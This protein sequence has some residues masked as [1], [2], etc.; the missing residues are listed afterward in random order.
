[1]KNVSSSRGPYPRLSSLRALRGSRR[2]LSALAFSLV[3]VVLVLAL[4]RVAGA[5]AP[6]L[7]AVSDFEART[8]VLAARIEWKR[9]PARPAAPFLGSGALAPPG[10]ASASGHAV[11]APPSLPRSLVLEGGPPKVDPDL[12]IASRGCGVACDVQRHERRLR[13]FTDANR[14]WLAPTLGGLA[15]VSQ[16]MLH[17]AFYGK[18]NKEEAMPLDKEDVHA[19]SWLHAGTVWTLAYVAGADP[20][21]ALG[22]AIIASFFFQGLLNL[23]ISGTFFD[24]NESTCWDTY[25]GLC[26]PKVFTGRNNYA[27]LAI[28]TAIIVVPRIIRRLR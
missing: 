8:G 20:V 3:P 25:G 7:S 23:G 21:D 1:M 15:F 12:F 28:G 4:A 24:E 18:A 26:V 11:F 22:S 13:R 17:G 5:Q 9:L 16:G 14:A 27:D 6:R 19:A 2:R 10:S